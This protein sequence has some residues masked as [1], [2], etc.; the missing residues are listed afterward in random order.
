MFVKALA[1]ITFDD[2]ARASN[3]E[4][5]PTFSGGSFLVDF[6]KKLM[7]ARERRLLRKFVNWGTYKPVA[8]T[9]RPTRTTNSI[10]IVTNFCW[11]LLFPW[12]SDRMMITHFNF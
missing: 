11:S 7:C 1:S 10:G 6:R 5:G 3:I 4:L 2:W 8:T 12:F 9:R